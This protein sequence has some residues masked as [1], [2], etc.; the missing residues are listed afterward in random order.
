MAKDATS[1][2]FR[3]EVGSQKGR[4]RLSLQFTVA[5]LNR[6]FEVNYTEEINIG[7]QYKAQISKS[8]KVSAF[9]SGLTI[10]LPKGTLRA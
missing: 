1:D 10:S 3:L 4:T 8:G 5:K 9:K 2:I 6:Q 7:S